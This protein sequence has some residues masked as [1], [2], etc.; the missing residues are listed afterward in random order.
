MTTT[1]KCR[2]QGGPINCTDQNCPQRKEFYAEIAA[3]A[4]QS[5]TKGSD[6]AVQ[7][8]G[9][10]SFQLHGP[11]LGAASGAALKLGSKPEVLLLGCGYSDYFKSWSG[12]GVA[13]G[14][15]ASDDELEYSFELTAERLRVYLRNEEYEESAPFDAEL[16]GVSD[17]SVLTKEEIQAAVAALVR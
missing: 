16:Q 17:I 4:T 9:E 15:A 13:P 10:A 12:T 1:A 8:V 11:D 5:L 14:Y 2:A 6:S 7:Q 3:Q